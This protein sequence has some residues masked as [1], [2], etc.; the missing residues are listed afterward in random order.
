MSRL[1]HGELYRR[2]RK[3]V[4]QKRANM[5]ISVTLSRRGDPTN[6]DQE[7]H[8]LAQFPDDVFT[9]VRHRR[10][11]VAGGPNHNE[12]LNECSLHSMARPLASPGATTH[13]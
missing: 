1:E 6:V 7:M 4:A 5:K 8:K 11:N 10:R 2:G 9:F 3:A 12:Q 13:R